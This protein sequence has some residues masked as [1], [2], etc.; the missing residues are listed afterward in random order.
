MPE[1]MPKGRKLARRKG[2]L[3]ERIHGKDP[4]EVIKHLAE[5]G[6]GSRKYSLVEV[7]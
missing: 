4:Y 1:G 5:L 3:F 2:H 7:E 6:L